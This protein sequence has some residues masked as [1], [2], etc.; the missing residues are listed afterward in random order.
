MIYYLPK[1]SAQNAN[2]INKNLDTKLNIERNA[3]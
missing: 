1:I 3:Y 2:A